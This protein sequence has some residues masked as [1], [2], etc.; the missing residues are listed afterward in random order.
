VNALEVL[1]GFLVSRDDHEER[2]AAAQQHCCTPD[3]EEF[4]L[5]R[6]GQRSGVQGEN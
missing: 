1:I 2:Y 5:E 3:N 4:D 6:K